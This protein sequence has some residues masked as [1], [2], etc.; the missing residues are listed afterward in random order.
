MYFGPGEWASGQMW[1]VLNER[2]FTSI[3]TNNISIQCCLYPIRLCMKLWHS[4]ICF[5]QQNTSNMANISQSKAKWQPGKSYVEQVLQFF[6]FY[7]RMHLI[8]LIIRN[9]D[10]LQRELSL[11]AGHPFKYSPTVLAATNFIEAFSLASSDSSWGLVSS[12]LVG[13]LWSE[14]LRIKREQLVCCTLLH[15]VWVSVKS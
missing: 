7:P 11:I 13:W 14:D 12:G 9:T 3:Q 6:R 10:F 5:N 1:M 15:N 8:N 4:I 2:Q